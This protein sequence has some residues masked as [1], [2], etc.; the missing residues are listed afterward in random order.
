ME[1]PR[2]PTTTEYTEIVKF[3]DDNLRQNI[4]WSVADEYPTVFSPGN[5]QNFRIIKDENKILSH[6][7]IKPTIIKTRRGLFKVG[8]I[9]SVITDEKHRNQG[10]SQTVITECLKEIQAQGCDFAILWTN[11]YDFYRK[12]GFE[13]AGSEVSLLI[14]KP[15]N[16]QHSFKILQNNR[17]D[18]QALLRVY[19]QHSVTSIRHI[20][21]FDKFLKIP[22][23]RLFTA[24]AAD[25]RLEGYAVEGK[26]A[27]LQGYIHEWGG[28][29]D[30]VCALTAHIQSTHK[31]PITLITPKHAAAL[32]RKFE[33]Y[34]IKSV[35]GFLGM[36][37]ITNP[38]LL[39]AKIIRNAK[40][41]FGIENFNLEYKE[42]F[43]YYGVGTQQ[44]KTDSERD[45]VRLLF[46]P[47]KPSEL[48]DHGKE[49]NEILD[50]FLPLEM[51]VW[52]W[53]SV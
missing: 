16:V 15:L 43:Y 25:G 49:L 29:V 39:F 51:W 26:G 2:A 21:E 1:G 11:L 53:D 36:I 32:I 37:K 46:G 35:E 30:A 40:M 4:Q 12:M 52:G 41:E 27:D 18:P 14:D 45:I 13:L 34:G 44:F 33:T 24:W 50:R 10:L 48:N 3:L 9:G 28:N 38:Q 6:A 8:C 19:N 5:L 17:V 20:D 47:Q 22:N 42:G 23:S 31:K 7:A